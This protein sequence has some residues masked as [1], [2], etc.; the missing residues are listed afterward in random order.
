MLTGGLVLTGA[1]EGRVGDTAEQIGGSQR[2]S[3]NRRSRKG[4]AWLAGL[5]A[6][7]GSQVCTHE[8]RGGC[9]RVRELAFSYAVCRVA[10]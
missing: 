9:L 2:S 7:R 10:R 5:R 1:L 4:A 3:T 8:V 6:L